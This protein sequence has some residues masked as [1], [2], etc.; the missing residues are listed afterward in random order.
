MLP[1][2]WFCNWYVAQRDCPSTKFK[3]NVTCADLQLSHGAV[4]ISPKQLPYCSTVRFLL[5]FTTTCWLLDEGIQC[6]ASNEQCPNLVL[7]NSWFVGHNN[8]YQHLWR[9]VFYNAARCWFF[10]CYIAQCDCPP[11]K[12]PWGAVAS[13]QPPPPYSTTVI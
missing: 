8:R 3:L 6:V 11:T 4:Q 5:I 10:N 1:Q 9:K 13:Q 7:S 12:N 2:G